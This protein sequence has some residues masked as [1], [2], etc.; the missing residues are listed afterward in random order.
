M[1]SA[2][3]P[4]AG[5]VDVHETSMES[6]MVGM[7]AVQRVEIPAGG[8]VAFQP[9]S[10]HLMLMDLPAELAAGK[11]IELDLVFEHA[12]T[13]VVKAEIRQG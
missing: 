13:V 2:S 10:Y 3:S 1:L 7:D 12:G 11:T 6:G 9:G 8:S 5:M 4:D